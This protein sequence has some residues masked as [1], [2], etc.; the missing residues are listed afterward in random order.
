MYSQ[1]VI[2]NNFSEMS[3]PSW[4]HWRSLKG[5]CSTWLRNRCL[6]CFHFSGPLAITPASSAGYSCMTS[7]FGSTTTYGE[8]CR[9]PQG[10]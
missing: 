5:C 1:P 6:K 7:S 10:L 2:Y 9:E 3:L 4:L 8:H